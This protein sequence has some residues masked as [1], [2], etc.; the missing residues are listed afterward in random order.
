M[1][2]D[3][4]GLDTADR[5]LQRVYREREFDV[6]QRFWLAWESNRNLRVRDFEA[7]N[8]VIDP[9]PDR[10][11]GEAAPAEGRHGR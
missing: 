11:V 7:A 6:A 3:V 1:T 10:S 9:E 8:L 5:A 4:D 2:S